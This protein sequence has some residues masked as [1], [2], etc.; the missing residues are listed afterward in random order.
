M[1]PT[2][3]IT[4]TDVEKADSRDKT[5]KLTVGRGLYVQIEPSGA[6]YWRF[7]YRFLGREKRLSL[8]IFPET[9]LQQAIQAANEARTLVRNGTDPS[10]L[11]K[12]AAKQ[13]TK[14][15]SMKSAFKFALSAKGIRQRRS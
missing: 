1:F 5:Y 12:E 9:S 6:K 7:K 8:G 3:H 2:P 11:R 4:S 13:K 10:A 14:P 15:L